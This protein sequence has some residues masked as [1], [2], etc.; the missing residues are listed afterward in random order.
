MISFIFLVC[1]TFA[2]NVNNGEEKLKRTSREAGTTS[3]RRSRR[4]SMNPSSEFQET[5]SGNLFYQIPNIH[6]NSLRSF[7]G[8][9]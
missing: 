9:I 2:E 8:E 3:R 5:F 4:W 1:F 6:Y 7:L